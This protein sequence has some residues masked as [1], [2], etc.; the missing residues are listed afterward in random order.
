MYGKSV[1]NLWVEKYGV[2]EANKRN[3]ERHIKLSNSLKGKNKKKI[4]NP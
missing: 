2:E 1:Y 3:E 4:L